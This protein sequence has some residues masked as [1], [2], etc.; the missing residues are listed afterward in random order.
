MINFKEDSKKIVSKLSPNKK[1]L[2]EKEFFKSAS[3]VFAFLKSNTNTPKKALNQQSLNAFYAQY[4]SYKK[5]E[6]YLEGFTQYVVVQSFKNYLQQINLKVRITW[7]P[8][9]SED[10]DPEH[11]LLYGKVSN[12]VKGFFIMSRATGKKDWLLPG[13]DINCG[14]T[15]K[16]EV[17]VHKQWKQIKSLKEVQKYIN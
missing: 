12:N 11:M 15:S 5:A 2:T 16:I 10:P 13:E 17:F 8:S 4:K 3:R 7:L 9:D 14:C 6:H 1:D